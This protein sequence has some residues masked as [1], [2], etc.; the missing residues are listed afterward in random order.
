MVA[1]LPG[2][3]SGLA[4]GFCETA[5]AEKA[6]HTPAATH[7]VNKPR[8]REPKTGRRMTGL[9]ARGECTYPILRRR[10]RR[11]KFRKAAE[12]GGLGFF[13]VSNAHQAKSLRR[14]CRP[15]LPAVAG[16]QDRLH[17]RDGPVTPAHVDQS[18]RDRAH[19][20]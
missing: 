19:H 18:A 10:L 1:G 13:L 5:V 9:Q 11:V 20:V 4:S 2:L 15:C 16:V 12:R 7:A 3:A 14:G 17:L 8:W 6:T